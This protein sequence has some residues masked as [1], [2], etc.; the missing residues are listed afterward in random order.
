MRR[1]RQ[2][3]ACPDPSWSNWLEATARREIAQHLLVDAQ[4]EAVARL[5][6]AAGVAFVLIK[7]SA[8]RAAAAVYPF[9]DARSTLDVDVLIPAARARG[10]C[11]LLR[12][13]GYEFATPAE[14]T[15]PGHYHERPLWDR[16]RVAVEVHT[17]TSRAVTPA[18]AWRRA[19]MGG[20]EARRDGLRLP[21]PSATEL[22]WHGLTHAL[23]LGAAGFRL[24]FFLDAAVVLA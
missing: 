8:R 15:P 5:L 11:D 9:A 23:G 13:S 18:V 16:S 24:R 3:N 12:A 7:G 19:T 4:V 2:R 20:C 14:A 1:L 10:A 22:L 6:T 21:I 17:S